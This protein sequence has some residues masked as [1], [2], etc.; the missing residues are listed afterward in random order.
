LDGVPDI[1]AGYAGGRDRAF[2][3]PRAIGTGVWGEEIGLASG[4]GVDVRSGV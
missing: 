1:V 2:R 4:I 3:A